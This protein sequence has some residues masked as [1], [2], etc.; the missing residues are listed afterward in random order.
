MKWSVNY[1]EKAI[2]DLHAIYEYIAY[3]LS[4]PIAAAKLVGR[5][6]DT[7]D[8]LDTNPIGLPLYKKEPWKS[9]GMRFVP[10]EKYIIFFLVSEEKGTVDVLRVMYGRRDIDLNT[11]NEELENQ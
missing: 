6:M 10:V 3:D 5:I 8:G 4:S 9:R 2:D 11:F 1:T 7:I